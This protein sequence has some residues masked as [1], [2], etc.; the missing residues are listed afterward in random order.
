MSRPVDTTSRRLCEALE[1]RLLSG[2]LELPLLPTTATTVLQACADEQAD[3]RELAQLIQRDAALAAHVLRAANSAACGPAEPIVTLQQALSRLGTRAVCEIAV[4]IAVKGKVFQVEGFED[5]AR[6]MW[7]HSARAGAWAREIARQRRRGVE[8]SF[9]A[10]L[11]HDVGRPVVLQAAAELA[12]GSALG[13]AAAVAVTDPLHARVGAGLIGRWG[14]S[15][16]LQLA[17]GGHHD[18]E[19]LGGDSEEAWTAQLADRLAHGDGAAELF[20]HAAPQALGLYPEDLEELLER[21][22]RVSEFARAFA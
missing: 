11:L 13:T 2:S 17:A 20:G 8:S 22:P 6:E 9:L 3:A 4:A 18:P 14:L 15:E 12:R 19:G 7:A 1:E 21:E 10:G 5:V 16:A